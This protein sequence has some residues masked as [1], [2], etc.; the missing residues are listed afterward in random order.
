MRLSFKRIIAIQI[1]LI[2]LTARANDSLS[3]RFFFDKNR[4]SDSRVVINIKAFVSNGVKLYALQKSSEDALYSSIE[5]DS[6]CSKYLAGS[7]IENGAV[8]KENDTA[9]GTTAIP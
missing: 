9:V 7:V 2:S 4:S 6:T 5:F 3:V 1:I 8:K